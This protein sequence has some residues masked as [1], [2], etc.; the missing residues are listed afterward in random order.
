MLNILTINC[1]PGGKIQLKFFLKNIRKGQ[2]PKPDILLGAG[3]ATHLDII[4]AKLKFGGKSV[5]IMKPTLPYCMF[6]LCLIPKHDNPPKR[7]NI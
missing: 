4:T 5:I 7:E 6:D 2:L 1:S 3:H